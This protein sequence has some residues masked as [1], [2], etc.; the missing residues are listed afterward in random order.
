MGL[1][2]FPNS[3]L[4]IVNLSAIFYAQNYL[5]VDEDEFGGKQKFLGEGF[6]P[7]FALFLV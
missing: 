2:L 5:N 4:F 7:S 1:K 6:M 3:Y